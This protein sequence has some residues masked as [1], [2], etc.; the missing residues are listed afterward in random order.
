MGEEE[1]DLRLLEAGFISFSSAASAEFMSYA[2]EMEK[3]K[4]ELYQSLMLTAAQ[5]DPDWVPPRYEYVFGDGSRWE[6]I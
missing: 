4:T 1:T 5:M 3:L 6:E 2:V